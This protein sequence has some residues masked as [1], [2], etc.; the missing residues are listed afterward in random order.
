[1][2]GKKNRPRLTPSDRKIVADHHYWQEIE[3]YLPW[4]VSGFTYRASCIYY[5]S[6]RQSLTISSEQRDQILEAV[7]K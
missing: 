7:R 4:D 6:D 1:M 2:A 5:T 3:K